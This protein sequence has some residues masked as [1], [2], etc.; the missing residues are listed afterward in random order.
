MNPKAK[1]DEHWTQIEKRRS[2]SDAKSKL[3]EPRFG[4]DLSSDELKARRF[5]KLDHPLT[6]RG[7][8]L[9]CAMIAS[10]IENGDYPD[11][12]RNAI[13]GD[14]LLVAERFFYEDCDR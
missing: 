7:F 9:G 4:E 6:N 11:T 5:Y 3:P 10:A 14:L 8:L 1:N 2:Q 13:L 12:R